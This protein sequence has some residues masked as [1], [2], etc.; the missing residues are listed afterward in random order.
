LNPH[1]I[2]AGAQQFLQL[3]EIFLSLTFSKARHM[4]SQT[5]N[6]FFAIP[7]PAYLF[8]SGLFL[9]FSTNCM[10]VFFYLDNLSGKNAAPAPTPPPAQ[11]INLL[12]SHWLI[13]LTLSPGLAS[14]QAGD[15]PCF[16][17]VDFTDLEF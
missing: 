13:K 2:R 16:S 8:F 4:I 12:A 5:V 11:D 9:H 6:F 14:I 15:P 17:L 3:L 7:N 10:P 1:E